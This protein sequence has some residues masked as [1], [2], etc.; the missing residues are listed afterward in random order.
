MNLTTGNEFL[1]LGLRNYVSK[2]HRSHHL[3]ITFTVFLSGESVK[4]ETSG[5][6]D[7]VVIDE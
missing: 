6:Y 4:L 1:V 3:W 5:K 2:A 7:V